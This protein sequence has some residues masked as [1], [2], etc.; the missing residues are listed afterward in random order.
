[1][2]EIVTCYGVDIM[3][4]YSNNRYSQFGEAFKEIEQWAFATKKI[5][6]KRGPTLFL[7]KTTNEMYQTKL[8][9]KREYPAVKHHPIQEDHGREVEL[10]NGQKSSE[11][12]QN[13]KD[14][15]AIEY[16]DMKVQKN[17]MPEFDFS[18]NYLNEATGQLIITT[19]WLGHVN[20]DIMILDRNWI[21]NAIEGN[22][23]EKIFKQKFRKYCKDHPNT[24][25]PV[26]RE[27]RD[28]I[29]ER[30]KYY[31]Y[32]PNDVITHVRYNNLTTLKK[33]L[34]KRKPEACPWQGKT[35][36]G[37]TMLFTSD[38]FEINIEF[39][40]REWYCISVEMNN[41]NTTDTP[42]PLRKIP[43]EDSTSVTATSTTIAHAEVMTPTPLP[44]KNIVRVPINKIIA[45]N[46]LRK[47]KLSKHPHTQQLLQI[48]RRKM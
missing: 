38:W 17:G 30:A 3:I 16:V 46:P 28:A 5:V 39:G 45:P 6:R 34:K 10:H 24:K 32:D 20:D 42:G 23:K 18:R 2:L 44:A 37:E 27:V 22:T 43:V 7:S 19:F 33:P 31:N 14:L 15:T 35:R 12:Y 25:I 1:M 41:D 8:P 21:F 48:Q 11:D 36:S 26:G 4:G 40:Q 47:K 13:Q 29:S 9:K